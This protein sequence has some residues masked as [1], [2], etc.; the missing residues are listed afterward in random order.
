MKFTDAYNNLSNMYLTS[1]HEVIRYEFTKES[2]QISII[3]THRNGLEKQMILLISGSEHMVALPVHFI[4]LNKEIEIDT[5]I[6][7]EYYS[8]LRKFFLLYKNKANEI[9]TNLFFSHLAQRIETI[10]IDNIVPQ[11]VHQFKAAVNNAY[12]IT[13]NHNLPFFN[14][15]VHAHMGKDM[16]RKIHRIYPDAERIIEFLDSINHTLR[17]TDDPTLARDLYIALTS[18]G[19]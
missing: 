16:R 18:M 11:N 14:T 13:N 6:D 7:N 9:S 4:S 19:Y 10:T 17:F 5:Y 8:L 1:G 3:Y 12:K 2:Y 15:L